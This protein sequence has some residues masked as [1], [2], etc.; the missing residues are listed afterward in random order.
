MSTDALQRRLG[1][2]FTDPA[3]LRQALTH[4]SH[5]RTH[6]ERLEF[7]GDS[8]LNCAVA[9]LLYQH[10]EKID[11]GDLS[12]LRAT[13][14]KQQSLYEIAQRLE[15]SPHLLLGEGELKSGGAKRPSILGDTLE[16]IVGAVY[17]D[18][19]F[20]AAKTL[21]VALYSPILKSVDPKTLGKDAKTLLQE[22]L[23]GRRVPLPIYSVVATHGAA[24]SQMFEVEC[25]IPKL[26]VQVL[27]RGDSRRA[28]EQA[29]ARLALDALQTRAQQAAQGGK[30]ARIRA[31]KVSPAAVP[32]SRASRQ[33]ATAEDGTP[34]PAAVAKAQAAGIDAPSGAT[35]VASGPACEA[36]TQ[37]TSAAASETRASD[38]G[39]PG[40]VEP[41]AVPAMPATGAPAPDSS[42]SAKASG[43]GEGPTKK[44]SAPAVSEGRA[45]KE[46][47]V[48][49]MTGPE[50]TPTAEITGGDSSK[51]QGATR[52]ERSRSAARTPR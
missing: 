20:D 36:A 5:G 1:Y 11:E 26:G 21:V 37:S 3:L 47:S 17:L 50:P 25:A 14:V 49:K 30:R 4:R 39:D 48:V 29:A 32:A 6:N 19:G 9:A 38:A 43:S 45:S 2:S 12:R 23:Q 10:F 13:L 35:S 41:A 51:T 31:D 33:A 42:E 46:P 15:L 16:A 18:G 44:S 28:A 7:L 27:G 24:H 34:A 40:D 8:V 22:H 52:G